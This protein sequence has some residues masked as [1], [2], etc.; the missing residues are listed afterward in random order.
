MHSEMIIGRYS[1]RG[2]IGASLTSILLIVTVLYGIRMRK[3]KVS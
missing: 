3:V 2:P 1:K